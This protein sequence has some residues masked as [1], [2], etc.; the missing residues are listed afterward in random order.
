MAVYSGVIESITFENVDDSCYVVR[1]KLDKPGCWEDGAPQRSVI[2]QGTILGITVQP[3][4]WF[5]FAAQAVRHA[6]YGWQFTITRAPVGA[7]KWDDQEIC[8]L[9]EGAGVKSLL[10]R[11][12]RRELGENLEKGL[13]DLEGL[14]SLPGFDL[15][16]A[17]F[18][19]E[20]W[21]SIKGQYQALTFLQEL[22]LHPQR[23]KAIWK[24]LGDQA[25]RLVAENPWGLLRVEGLDLRQADSVA[26][27]L[28]FDLS[29]SKRLEG[30]VLHACRNARSFGHMFV[31][32]GQIV[33]DTQRSFPDATPAQ[34]MQQLATF[35]KAQDIILEKTSRGYAVYEPWF[36]N[37]EVEGSRLLQ[38]RVKTPRFGTPEA[39]ADYCKALGNTGPLTRTKSETG[40]SI[41][42]VVE[43]AITEWQQQTGMRLSANQREAVLNGLTCTVS[44]MTGLPGTGKST[45]SK[46]VCQ[47][48]IQAGVTVLL[49]A[50]TG[51]AAKRLQQVTG[52]EA[53]TI[54]MA[55]SAKASDEGE[56]SR[57]S[58]YAGVT[59]DGDRFMSDGREGKW[60]YG[61]GNP[62]PADFIVIDE[63]SMLDSN[64]LF[65]ILSCTK[66]NAGIMLVGDAA[67]LPSVGP[68]DV[69]RS[70]V[71]SGV[72]PTVAL[73][74]IY[75][76]ASTSYIVEAAH[77]IN[78]GQTPEV[79]KPDF[80][81]VPADR[82]DT[83]LQHL[84]KAATAL[85]ERGIDYQVMSPKH[86]GTLGVTNLNQELRKLINPPES[87]KQEYALGGESL[88]EGDR[89]MVI[90]NSYKLGIVNGDIGK[91]L[92]IDRQ[93]KVVVAQFGAEHAEI[94]LEDVG[95]LLRMA[96]ATTVHKC[97]APNTLVTTE[98][99]VQE[100]GSIASEGQILT[101]TGL[102]PYRS[103]VRNPATLCY[104]VTVDTG[105]SLTMTSGHSMVVWSPDGDRMIE[106]RDLEVGDMLFNSQRLG[107]F[108]TDIARVESETVCL[109][110]PDGHQFIQ[111]G[112]LGGNCQGQE[113]DIVLIPIHQS[114]RHQLQR[115][116]L[117]TA[118]TR[119]KKRVL[120]FGQKAALTMAVQNSTV[121]QRNTLLSE[122]L[123]PGE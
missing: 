37:L 5:R 74:E 82:E 19:K 117:Y 6:K 122:R 99:G 92:R 42:E 48:L 94:P 18:L 119:A 56:V 70:V 59:D 31:T 86:T 28:G 100:I 115:N 3:G 88:R 80:M 25:P 89:V 87:Y 38:E 46:A 49:C 111:N 105:E 53:K 40:A 39:E 113:M 2:A 21:L 58:G 84:L 10:T 123:S 71:R 95:Q 61:P 64:L 14:A 90:K 79:D 41:Q 4:V 75:R 20:K 81:L 101:E 112:L 85:S 65:R 16:T 34:I 68:G 47:I 43:T 35:H 54:H 77:M 9:L 102:K 121:D 110:V 15:P 1:V 106:A 26:V 76:Q 103:L 97:V 45:S 17:Q 50:P 13:E 96:Y 22:G 55:F 36:H 52:H 27:R 12:L 60:G 11:M 120:L 109:E 69:L 73:T 24:T 107:V 23:L 57:E 78:A 67:Q 66:P 114:F 8:H 29:D 108:I 44:C 93:N 116:L 62:H 104:Q 7:T 32:A 51:I 118:V 98:F 33:L 83:I 91:V 63:S 72:V 30:V